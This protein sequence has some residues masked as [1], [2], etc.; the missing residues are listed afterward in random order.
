MNDA[1]LSV[2]ADQPSDF[3]PDVPCPS[4]QERPH[5]HIAST[6]ADESIGSS[7]CTSSSLPIKLRSEQVASE[8]VH[9]LIGVFIRWKH[10]IEDMFDAPIPNDQRK[11]LH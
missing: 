10:R 9:N 6:R 11:T 1:R 5:L 2:T 4:K 3:M 7:S 8:P